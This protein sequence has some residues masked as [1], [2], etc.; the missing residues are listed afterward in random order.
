MKTD[1]HRKLIF[2][3]LGSALFV[4]SATPQ[5]SKRH[6]MSVSSPDGLKWLQI[7]PGNEM[8]VV[9][10]ESLHSLLTSDSISF[11]S[12]SRRRQ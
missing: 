4:G 1:M 5:E 8:A 6:Q 12:A 10:D 7:R 11:M 9:Y 3:V 2:I